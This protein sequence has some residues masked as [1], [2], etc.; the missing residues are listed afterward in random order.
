MAKE[1][2]KTIDDIGTEDLPDIL[3]NFWSEV[4]PTDAVNKKKK[5]DKENISASEKRYANTTLNCMRAA[6]NRHLKE[7]RSVDMMKDAKFTKAK[8]N[9]ERRQEGRERC[10]AT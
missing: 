6:I 2:G 5:T 3:Y 7:T 9:F 4:I 8:S 1:N 10:C